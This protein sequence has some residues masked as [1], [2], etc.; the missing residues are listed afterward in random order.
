M[1]NLFTAIT[2]LTAAPALA[3]EPDPHFSDHMVLQRGV[4]APVWGKAD[5]GAEVSVTFAGKT[6]TTKA[7]ADGA[8]RVNLPAM[9]ASGENREMTVA[10]GEK[11]RKIANVLVGDVW[12]G[13]GQSNMAGGVAGY[14]KKDP[15]LA[16]LVTKAPFPA[17]RLLR[18]GSNPTWKPATAQNVTAFSAILFAFGE[19]LHRDLDVP[20]GL[21]LGAVGG[22]PSG[23]WIPPETY[24]S[25]EKC[26]AEVAEFAKT[27]DRDQAM[28]QYQAKLEAWEKLAAE[29]KAAGKKPRGRQPRQP[30]EPGTSTRGGNV[31][32]LF[33]RHIRPSVGYGIR[34][35]LWDQGEARSGIQGLSQYTA[36]SE[37]IRGWRELW[38]Q[39]EFPFIFVQKPSGQGNAWSKDDPITREADPFSPLPDVA[40]IGT[41]EQRFTYVRLMRDNPGAWMVPACDLGSSVHPINKWGYGNRAAQVAEQMVY[42]LPGVQAFGPIYDS[43][44]VNG[45]EVTVRFTQVGEGLAVRHSDAVQGF[46]L[47]GEDGAWHWAAARIA[48]PDTVVLTAEAVASPKHVRFAYATNRRWANLFNKAGL[49]AVAFATDAME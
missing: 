3:L 30:A 11:S 13:S 23:F 8:W 28:K 1:R 16:E 34:G 48:G 44:E 49:P 26:R 21:I 10:S 36:M 19:R 33:D 31:G 18:G 14:Q 47:A 27:W 4:E 7:E 38:G 40:R 42:K 39:G 20:V 6:V 37:L 22:T 41:G 2:I 43:H 17:M 46:A 15:T 35:V 25:S 9:E 45:A 24:E 29:A 12:V 32:N 5:P